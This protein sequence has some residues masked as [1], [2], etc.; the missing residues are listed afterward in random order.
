MRREVGIEPRTE[1]EPFV[2]TIQGRK[3]IAIAPVRGQTRGELMVQRMKG[4]LKG[5]GRTNRILRQ[6]RGER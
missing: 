5:K 4:F 1:V 6:T 3:V 2:A